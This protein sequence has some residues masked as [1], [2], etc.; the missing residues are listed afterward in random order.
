M[1]PGRKSNPKYFLTIARHYGVL[2]KDCLHVGD[3]Q[4]D[5]YALDAGVPVIIIPTKYSRHIAFDPRCRILK[6]I[7]ALPSVLRFS[8]SRNDE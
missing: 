6:S 4:I 7:G 1:V 2:P 5:Q 3:T 8:Q